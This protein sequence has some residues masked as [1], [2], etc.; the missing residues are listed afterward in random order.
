MVARAIVVLVSLAA[1]GDDDRYTDTVGIVDAGRWMRPDLGIPVCE[2]EPVAC[3]TYFRRGM[4]YG[5]R[6]Q[7]DIL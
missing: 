1:C 6:M 4:R 3:S 7:H 5:G 2:G